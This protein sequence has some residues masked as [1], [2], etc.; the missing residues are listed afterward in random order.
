MNRP[1]QI[2]ALIDCPTRNLHTLAAQLP[3]EILVVARDL[4]KQRRDTARFTIL[5]Y[6]VLS[7]LG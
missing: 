1:L 4:A 3:L 7:R 5:K 2:Q 6:A